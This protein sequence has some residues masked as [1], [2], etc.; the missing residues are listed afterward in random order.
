[1]IDGEI[2]DATATLELE[3]GPR[4]T[5]VSGCPRQWRLHGAEG[6]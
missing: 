3:T 1:M 6:K 4:V 5:M 2:F